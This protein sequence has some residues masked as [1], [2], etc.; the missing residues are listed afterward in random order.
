MIFPGTR[1]G[2]KSG[3]SREQTLIVP[4]ARSGLFPEK[5]S[6]KFLA[7]DQGLAKDSRDIYKVNHW[8]VLIPSP[9][10]KWPVGGDP[11]RIKMSSQI[12]SYK[13]L[14]LDSRQ[15]K[16]SLDVKFA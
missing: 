4:F 11:S 13:T 3:N 15:Q 16:K 1:E 12:L 10:Q 7:P 2:Q 14:E 6:G 5:P 8:V 9:A